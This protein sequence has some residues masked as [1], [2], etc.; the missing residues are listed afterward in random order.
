MG[1]G[2]GITYDSIAEEEWEESLLKGRFLTHSQAAFELF[3]TIL[4]Q[5]GT[6][7]W[8][9]EEHLLRLAGGAQFFKFSCDLEVV[10]SQLSREKDS[11]AEG[12]YRVRL[13]LAKDG[14]ITLSSLPCAAPLFTQ[15][16][17]SQFSEVSDCPLVDFSPH[18]VDAKSPWLYYKTT[19]RGLYDAQYKEAQKNGLFDYIFCNSAGEVT[20]GCISN[21]IIFRQ[22]IYV[23]PP[24][25]SGLLSGVM[26]QHILEDDTV[27]VDEKILTRQDVISAEAIF[28]CNSVR[29]I[30]RVKL[31]SF[32]AP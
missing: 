17:I 7:Y 14:R 5:P 13:V 11:F 9:L 19:M 18:P 27:P 8:L 12:C 6:G 2:A 23:T 32:N 3:E 25:T 31:K 26:R 29:G 16:S 30:V 4:W 24:V 10:R 22:G 1:I 15:L 21:I 28:V 20:E